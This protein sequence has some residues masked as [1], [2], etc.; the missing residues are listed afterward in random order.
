[1]LR[2][3]V[4]DDATEGVAST[5]NF[6]ELEAAVLAVAEGV[7]QDTSDLDFERTLDGLDWVRFVGL[8]NAQ[9]IVE[10]R[11]VAVLGSNVDVA[12]I[13]GKVPVRVVELFEISTYSMVN[14]RKEMD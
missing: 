7:G 4:G 3:G 8:A 14:C 9:A 5:Y 11:S 1:M 6:L 13:F 12:V 2:D 10:E